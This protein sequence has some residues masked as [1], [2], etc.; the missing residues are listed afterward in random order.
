MDKKR[1]DEFVRTFF[2][3]DI[4]A[5]TEIFGEFLAAMAAEESLPPGHV[6]SQ[7]YATARANPE[8]HT[9]P[10]NLKDARDAV[11]P[12]FWGTDGWSS[13]LHLEN[14][15]GPANYASFIGAVACLLKNPNLCTDTYSQR[16]NE[17]EVKAITA[18]AN[19]I[20]YNTQDP[21]G[22]F[23][24][25][26]THSNMYGA[27][28]GLE[29]VLP[30]AM[31][32]GIHGE[33]VV[34]LVSAAS[35][36]SNQTVAGWVGIGTKNLH[37][38]P[39]D[40]SM[41]MRVSDL[42]E[43]L[44]RLYKQNTK[45]AYV[46]ATFGTTDAFGI[47][48]VAE[49]RRVIDEKAT[50]FQVPKP[51]LHADAAVGWALCFLAD[52]DTER[53]PLEMTPELLPVVRQAQSLC[54]GLKY[55]DSVTLD[56]HKMGRG[57]YP[58]SAFI[59]N[60]RS[61]LQYLARRVEDTPYFSDADSRRDP[62]LF[63]LETSRPGLGPYTVMASLNGIGMQGWQMLVAH[64]LELADMLKRKLDKLEYC[65]VL[66]KDTPGASV[67]WWV[68][69]K[70]RNAKVI[71][72]RIVADDI[73]TE[74]AH[75]YFAEVRRLFDK[76]EKTMAPEQDARLSFTTSVGYHPLGFD[77]PAWKAVFFNPKTDES[78]IDRLIYSIEEL[79]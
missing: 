7:N 30:G 43:T 34:G 52:Y 35:H 19:L 29:K 21:W 79:A 12:Y 16:S 3:C 32:N 56:F 50:E 10:G 63:T 54:Q 62:A 70:G 28:I 57:H 14:V 46:V 11:F 77:I 31:R 53:N 26:G 36:Y 78:V 66:N 68:L 44:D 51:H 55:A 49:I 45:V 58:S 38:I 37:V 27:R 76:R 73:S 6:M 13:P 65:I 18:L 64:S 24:L 72:E 48:D 1:Y 8:I 40:S 69:P 42:A 9:L 15:R 5:V 61:D 33:P 60:R 22:I 4:A 25:G 2:E 47:D 74:E 67:C 59:V 17:L 39:T 71:Y 20:F 23:T 75:R 41:S